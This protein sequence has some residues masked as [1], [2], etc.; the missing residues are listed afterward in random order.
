MLSGI[1][2]KFKKYFEARVFKMVSG[3]VSGFDLDK[4]GSLNLNSS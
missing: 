1:E 4:A 3:V 2:E